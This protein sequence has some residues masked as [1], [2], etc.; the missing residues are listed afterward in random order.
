[1]ITVITHEGFTFMV[2]KILM[3]GNEKNFVLKIESPAFRKATARLAE[4][5][6][7]YNL[8][9]IRFDQEI[10]LG[11]LCLFVEALDKIASDAIKMIVDACQ[12]REPAVYDDIFSAMAVLTSNH[13]Q[14]NIQP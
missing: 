9:D 1:M 14:F 4:H 3:L 8:L 7:S 6:G 5:K 2:T 13:Q 12:E 11:G 10:G